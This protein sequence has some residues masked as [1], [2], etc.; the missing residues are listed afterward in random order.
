MM[1]STRIKSH[2]WRTHTNRSCTP[3]RVALSQYASIH[4]K[5][6]YHAELALGAGWGRR[7]TPPSQRGC[8]ATLSPHCVHGGALEWAYTLVVQVTRLLAELCRAHVG[9]RK[10]G[11]AA[12]D[13]NR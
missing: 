12:N 2:R 6:E 4:A 11:V 9:D 13:A 7:W 10:R 1:S 3:P 5:P 8:Q